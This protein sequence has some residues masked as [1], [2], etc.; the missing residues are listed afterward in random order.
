MHPLGPGPVCGLNK[1][2]KEILKVKFEQVTLRENLLTHESK[3]TTCH[4][5][6]FQTDL[7]NFTSSSKSQFTI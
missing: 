1:Q 2:K 5:R 4:N 6:N 7:L 3:I